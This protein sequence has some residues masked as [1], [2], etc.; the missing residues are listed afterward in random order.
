M[1]IIRNDLYLKAMHGQFH[2]SSFSL[3]VFTGL[4]PRSR[5]GLTKVWGSQDRGVHKLHDKL[6]KKLHRLPSTAYDPDG[7]IISG[8]KMTDTREKDCIRLHFCRA[9]H[10]RSF[11]FHNGFS[12]RVQ[13]LSPPKF[14]NC[15]LGL[16]ALC[17]ISRRR[18]SRMR[19][20]QVM[21][22]SYTSHKSG[23]PMQWEENSNTC[24][25]LLEY[26]FF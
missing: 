1:T 10:F 19:F 15:T 20:R 2:T 14:K 6:W 13:F 8:I 22:S 25:V 12:V 3:L 16:S 11:V 7:L 18:G 9:S 5:V 24:C 21:K 17:F 26:P 4:G 23:L